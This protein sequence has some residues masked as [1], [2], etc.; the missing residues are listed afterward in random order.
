[1]NPVAACVVAAVKVLVGAYPRWRSAVVATGQSIYFANHTSHLDTLAIWS[2][3]RPEVRATTRPVAARD[4]WGA[5]RLRR[6]VAVRVLNAVLIERQ[7]ENRQGDPL[8]PL[9]SALEQ[10]DSLILF[11][12]GTRGSEPL[13]SLFKSG[14][15]HLARRFPTVHLIP[16]YLENLNRVMPK[17]TPLPIPLICTVHFGEALPRF[18]DEPKDAFLDRARAAVVGL[19]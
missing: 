1:M 16:V 10:G 17:G 5:G 7:Q 19:A 9:I 2:A 13:P 3:L 12:E 6:F 11:P 18:A 14:I 4:Y 8:Q 15:Y